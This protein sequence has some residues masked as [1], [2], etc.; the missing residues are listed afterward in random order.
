MR[1]A[2]LAAKENF[3]AGRPVDEG[4]VRPEI[5]DSWK[6]SRQFGVKPTDADKSILTAEE[7]DERIAAHQVFYDIAVPF[8]ESLNSFTTGSGFLTLISDEEGYVLKSI[9][10][11]D[12]LR[13]A[14]ENRLVEGCNRSERRLGTNAI[15]TCI[16]TRTPIQIYGHEHYY[17]MHAHWVCC[18]APIFDSLGRTMGAFCIVGPDDKVTFH[19]LGM[20]AAAA[21]AISRQL[22]MKSAYD[23]IDSDHKNLSAIIEHIPSSLLLLDRRL[24]VKLAN[25]RAAHF[26]KRPVEEIVGK[27]FA[28]LFGADTIDEE[29]LRAGVSDRSVTVY[30]AGREVGLSLT[31]LLTDSEEYLVTFERSEALHKKLNKIIGS[32]ASF[33]FDDIVGHSPV[34]TTTVSMARI[35][36]EN[37][38]SVLL[39][40]ESGTGKELFAQAIHNASDRRDEPF[41]ALNCGALPKSLIESELFGYEGG[42]FTGAKREGRAGK[43]ELANGGTIFLDEIGD[44]PFDVQASLLRVLQNREVMR[45]GSAK[46]VPIN[47]RVI[48]ATNQDLQSAIADGSFRSDLFYRLNVFNITLPPLRER[49]GD[50]RTLADYFFDKYANYSGAHV[51]GITEEAY[52]V[53]SQYRWPGNIR[54]LE[55]VIERAVYLAQGGWVDADMLPPALYAPAPEAGKLPAL[56]SSIG[57]TAASVGGTAAPVHHAPETGGYSIKQSERRQIE[58]ALHSTGGNVKKAAE[59]LEISRRTLYRKLERYGIQH[60]G[61]ATSVPN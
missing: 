9:G 4:I 24:T 3:L 53:M 26:F 18:G 37:S 34:I 39:I 33:V 60:R 44:M 58:N 16:E 1:D 49:I 45:I 54:E 5:L 11:E 51:K 29:A 20:A 21:E 22:T 50:V 28:Q 8:M 40:G 15:G 31:S 55:N 38:S 46:T 59:V 47:V 43:F 2:I 42:S 19:T 30:M 41:I 27:G 14:A 12:I 61:A 7:L 57:G 23:I 36:A 48:A 17:T 52:A 56:S 25:S 32:S 13:Q 6:R 10:D 35:A